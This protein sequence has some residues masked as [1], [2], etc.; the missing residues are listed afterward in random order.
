MGGKWT[1]P[2]LSPP[3]LSSPV[4]FP[5]PL[6]SPV[7]S[8]HSGHVAQMGWEVGEGWGGG[9]RVDRGVVQGRCV[10]DALDPASKTQ[11]IFTETLV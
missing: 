6:S 11:D 10:R 1:S 8:P 2:V 5:P 4:H 3:H 9:G 7:L